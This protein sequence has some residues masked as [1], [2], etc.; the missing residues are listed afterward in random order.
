MPQEAFPLVDGKFSRNCTEKPEKEK[1][2]HNFSL[3]N[4]EYSFMEKEIPV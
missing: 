4:L 3:D 1:I 2:M